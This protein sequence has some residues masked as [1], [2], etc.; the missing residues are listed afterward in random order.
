[1]ENSNKQKRRKYFVDASVQGAILRQ[2]VF[3][4]LFGFATFA[5]VLF[6]YRI[7]PIWLAGE[8][9]TFQRIWYFL[10]PAVVSSVV[11]LPAVMYRAIRF[12]HRFVGPMV[13]FRKTINQLAKGQ[14]VAPIKLRWKDFWVDFA[15]DLN[16]L[17]TKINDQAA[18]QSAE[19]AS[20]ETQQEPR[21]K[22]EELVNC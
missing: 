19:N 15:N 1:M 18:A 9:V 8:E 4:W 7:V 13:R 16:Q 3:Y 12:S 21:A 2:A 11:L 6:A 10:S 17:S 20:A 14:T 5:F 22:E